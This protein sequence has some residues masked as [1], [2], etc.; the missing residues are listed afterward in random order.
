MRS[1]YPDGNALQRALASLRHEG[2]RTFARKLASA[3]GW[4]RMLRLERSLCDPIPEFTPDLPIEF[5]MLDAERIDAYVAARPGADRATIERLLRGGR[6]CFVIRHQ[7]RI[8]SSCW[9]TTTSTWSAFVR[10]EIE[11]TEGDVYFTDAWTHPHLRGHGLAHA[12]CLHQLR[13]YRDLGFRRAIRC[14]IPE[15]PSALRTH[16]KSGFRPTVMI[17]RLRLGPWQRNLDRPWRER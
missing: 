16:M 11:L 15:N 17:S 7:G 5:G 12:L 4:R 9:S 2:A 6:Q 3:L 10:T 14:T 13:R 1:Y 8:V